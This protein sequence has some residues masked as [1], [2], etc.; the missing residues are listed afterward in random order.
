MGGGGLKFKAIF[1]LTECKNWLNIGVPQMSKTDDLTIT[2]IYTGAC[3]DIFDIVRTLHFFGSL[4]YNL[5][6]QN[7]TLYNLSA[8]IN[9][10]I[11]ISL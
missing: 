5:M 8:L 10:D 7:L 2:K 6:S 9:E 4:Y 11:Y 1:S 3:N